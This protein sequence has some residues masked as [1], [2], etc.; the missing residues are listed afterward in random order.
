SR[1]E[2]S[3]R[4]RRWEPPTRRRPRFQE[5]AT[6]RS[7]VPSPPSSEPEADLTPADHG[8]S[9]SC[10]GGNSS[11]KPLDHPTEGDLVSTTQETPLGGISKEEMQKAREEVARR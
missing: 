2:L 10:R 11:G 5:P 3:P 6:N 7:C 1:P 9:L 8:D 4:K